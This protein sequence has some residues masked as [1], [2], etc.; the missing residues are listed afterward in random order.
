M[1][2]YRHAGKSTPLRW[3]DLLASQLDRLRRAAARVE[4]IRSRSG[5]QEGEN[6][7]AVGLG[8][9]VDK[10]VDEQR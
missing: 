4:L 3:N 6:V 7:P 8:V 10:V 5:S 2:H 9:L 1:E